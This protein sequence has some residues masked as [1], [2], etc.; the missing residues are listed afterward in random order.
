MLC[1]RKEVREHEKGTGDSDLL[2]D[3]TGLKINIYK[4]VLLFV[5]IKNKYSIGKMKTGDYSFIKART[6][7]K[8][9]PG[10]WSNRSATKTIYFIV[11]F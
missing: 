8:P 7:T 3:N 11:V 1:S 9:S 10:F 6:L 4:A 2:S 5:S